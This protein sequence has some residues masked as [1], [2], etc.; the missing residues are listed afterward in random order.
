MS[1][2]GRYKALPEEPSRALTGAVEVAVENA[3]E[4]FNS[5]AAGCGRRM[6]WGNQNAGR[7]R[8]LGGAR[9]FR[10]PAPPSRRCREADM[11][12]S[13]FIVLVACWGLGLSGVLALAVAI[14]FFV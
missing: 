11:G 3:S 13:A 7:T 12:R 2:V 10:R 6:N 8:L 5:S 1:N 9:S 14:R 4:P